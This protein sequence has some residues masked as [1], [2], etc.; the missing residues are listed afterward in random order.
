M[1]APSPW[2]EV[3]AVIPDLK[4]EAVLITGAS[5]SIAAA[6]ARCVRSSVDAARI[7][8]AGTRMPPRELS[9]RLDLKR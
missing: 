6:A 2:P 3:T 4:G 8:Q 5:T 1:N 7:S 9:T